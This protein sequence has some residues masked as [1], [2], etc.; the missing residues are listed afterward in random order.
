MRACW[1]S[2]PDDRPS[3][4]VIIRRLFAMKKAVDAEQSTSRDSSG[5]SG[6]SVKTLTLQSMEGSYTKVAARG[7][8]RDS[9]STPI[10]SDVN[11]KTVTISG[12][13][14]AEDEKDAITTIVS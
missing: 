1:S 11:A 4:D 5:A 12:T 3:F 8:D 2:A 13:A 14:P 10:A 9:E 6:Q 7:A